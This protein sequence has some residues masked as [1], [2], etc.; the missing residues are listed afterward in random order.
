[1]RALTPRTHWGRIFCLKSD[2]FRP[3]VTK[4]FINSL[5]VSVFKNS[6]SHCDEKNEIISEKMFFSIVKYVGHEVS[7]R[8]CNIFKIVSIFLKSRYSEPRTKKNDRFIHYL[9]CL[10]V[11]FSFQS[12]ILGLGLKTPESRAH[13]VKLTVF[14]KDSWKVTKK[15]HCLKSSITSEAGRC[16]EASTST[17]SMPIGCWSGCMPNTLF[18]L[19]SK[20]MSNRTLSPETKTSSTSCPMALGCLTGKSKMNYFT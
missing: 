15:N 8:N 16:W 18:M 5:K 19:F 7:R 3:C 4:F 11:F 13:Y 20:S 9:K 10:E 2:L 17:L 14:F 6:W 12:H 1:M